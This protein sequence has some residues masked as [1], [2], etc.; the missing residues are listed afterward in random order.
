VPDKIKIGNGVYAELGFTYRV[1][2]Y[3]VE[4]SSREDKCFYDKYTWLLENQKYLAAKQGMAIAGSIKYPNSTKATHTQ[5]E[6]LYDEKNTHDKNTLHDCYIYDIKNL[7]FVQIPD[8]LKRS[9]WHLPMH[10][11]FTRD[12]ETVWTPIYYYPIENDAAPTS[13]YIE[14][15]KQIAE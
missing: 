14:S 12:G 2:S 15:Q 7:T 13:D 11:D 5:A 4:G 10:K 6:V 9:Y 1:L 8:N 3:A